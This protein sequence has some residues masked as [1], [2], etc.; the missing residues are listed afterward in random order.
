MAQKIRKG[1]KVM[2][3]RGK[4]KGKTGEVLEVLR[5][6]GRVLIKDV[7]MV[8]KHVKEIPNVREG[9]IYQ[10]EAPIHVSN[11]MLLCPKCNKPT[12]VGIRTVVEGDTLRKY[13][14]CKKCNE[15]IDLIREKVRA[16][17]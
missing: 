5:E 1:D 6:K 2:V 17:R 11:I 8:Y 9:G 16:K 12:R 7:N 10:I 14:Y 15:N 13:R 3:L 4:E